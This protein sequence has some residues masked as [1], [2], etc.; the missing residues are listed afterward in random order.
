MTTT[1][2]RPHGAR[3]RSPLALPLALL[4]PLLLAACGDSDVKEIKQWMDETTRSTQVKVTPIAEPKTF[5]PFAY[6]AVNEID[7]YDPNKLLGELARAAETAEN[8]LKPD[9]KRRKEP[10]EAYPLDS[11]KM[12][13]TLR[14]RGV[15]Y[16]LLQIDRTVYHVRVGERLGQNYGLITSLGDDAIGIKETIQDA[17]GE[18]VERVTKLELQEGKETGK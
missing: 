14:S 5:I 9:A 11:M 7:P 4:M 13:G 17:G 2:M 18:W 3:T 12:V 15:T 1:I 16:G 10:L 8:P 6:S